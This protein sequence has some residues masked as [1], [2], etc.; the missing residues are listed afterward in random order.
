MALLDDIRCS[1]EEG[2][3]RETEKLI[4]LALSEKI[5]TADILEQGITAMR[6]AGQLY[7]NNEIYIARILSAARAMRCGLDILEP[8]L[9][10]NNQNPIGSVILGT[11]EGDLHDV[12]KNLVAI[13]FRSAGFEVIDLGVDVSKKRFLKTLDERPDVFIVCISALLT[14]T[15]PEM[16][17]VVQCLRQY[18]KEGRL[19]IMVGGAPI[20]QEFADAIG[21]DAYTENAADAPIVAKTFLM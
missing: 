9:E 7:K 1:I 21:A 14:T 17:E 18:D 4:L 19:R 15:M 2:H 5:S 8:H 3:P 12:G 11:V 6:N 13:M 10:V 16:H 20:T